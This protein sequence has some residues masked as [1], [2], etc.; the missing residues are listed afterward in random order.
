MKYI[1]LLALALVALFSASVVVA[2]EETT[3]IAYDDCFLTAPNQFT[4]GEISGH[5]YTA[6]SEGH[7]AT[8][9]VLGHP[10]NEPCPGTL[11]A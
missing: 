2:T 10:Y 7:I 9:E 1:L 5:Q 8:L 6:S 4:D 11:A 3:T